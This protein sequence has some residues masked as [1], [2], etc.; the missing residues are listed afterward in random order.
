MYGQEVRGE[1]D[2]PMREDDA[3]WLVERTP[4]EMLRD[5]NADV[6]YRHADF[7]GRERPGSFDRL[8][9]RSLP[10]E[11]HHTSRRARF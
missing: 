5:L 11:V 1:V 10:A 3:A 6:V 2:G 4:L 9:R 8:Q 7:L